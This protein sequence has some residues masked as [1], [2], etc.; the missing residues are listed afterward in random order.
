M[1]KL[2][3]YRAFILLICIGFLSLQPEKV[4]G[5]RSID[6]VQNERI[7][8][9]VALKDLQMN[10]SLAPATAPSMVLDPNQSNKRQV[11]KGSDPIHNRC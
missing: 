7:L 4:S 1:R 5:L 8:K 2:L 11:G 10:P 9:A 6:F 3:V